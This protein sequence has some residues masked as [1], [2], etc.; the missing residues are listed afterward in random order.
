MFWT[1][2]PKISVRV[3]KLPFLMLAERNPSTAYFLQYSR[4]NHHLLVQQN[5][6]FFAEGDRTLHWSLVTTHHI[7]VLQLLYTFRFRVAI[8]SV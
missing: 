3:A 6:T 4:Q 2:S 8:G 5:A 7:F 1:A